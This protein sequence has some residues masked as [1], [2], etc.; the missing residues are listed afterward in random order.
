LYHKV[1][2]ADD[3]IEGNYMGSLLTMKSQD[4]MLSILCLTRHR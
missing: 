2:A 4:G 3:Y 1:K